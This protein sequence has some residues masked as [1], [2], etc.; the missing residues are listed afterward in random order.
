MRKIYRKKAHVG[1]QL[2]LLV[3]N[4][5]KLLTTTFFLSLSR[6]EKEGEGRFCLTGAAFKCVM[7]T[8]VCVFV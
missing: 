6:N 4:K 1:S 7:F 2:E 3:F 8:C 5:S